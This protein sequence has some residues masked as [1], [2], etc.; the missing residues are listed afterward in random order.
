MKQAV[1]V[2]AARTAVGK[3]QGTLS[4]FRAPEL[5][6]FAIKAALERAGVKPDSVD[7]VILG[8]VLQA[9]V[10]QNPARQAALGAGFDPSIA[11]FTINKVCGSGLKSVALAAQAIRAGDGEVY[12]AGGMESMTNAPYMLRKARDG[13]RLG[14]GEVT[15]S[16]VA[17]GLWDVYEDFHM[18][19]TAELVAEKY[20]VPRNTQDAYAAASHQR[21][22]A[23]TE[24][25]KFDAEITPVEVPQR[26]ADPILFKTDEGIRAG[27]TADKM[28]APPLSSWRRSA[29][30]RRAA[31][32][33]HASPATPPAASSPSGS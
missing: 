18:G 14:H 12:V 15:D 13:I 4:G 28:G 2:G 9:G 33:S 11:A 8:C 6:T 24:A 31:R 29:R 16:M 19:N 32:R 20:D 17:D 1:I 21:A 25:G 27:T 10:G 7:E 23:A 26:K 5:G 30:R 3:F 22:A